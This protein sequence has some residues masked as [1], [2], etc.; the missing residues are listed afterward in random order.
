MDLLEKKLGEAGLTCERHQF[1]LSETEARD[2]T[3]VSLLA[4]YGR[5]ERTLH[6]H[7]HY[8]V[9]PAQSDGQFQPERKE[10]TSAYSIR[11]RM[12]SSACCALSSD[13]KD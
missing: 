7:G 2:E 13:C 10:H 11:V 12:P 6:F 3:A 4:A 5:G 9:V 8:D 1:P